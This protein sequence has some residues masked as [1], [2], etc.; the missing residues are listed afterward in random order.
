MG[1]KG[2]EG[3]LERAVEGTFSRLFRSGLSPVEFGRKLVRE[4]DAHRT[5]G[6]DGRTIVP[7]AF[8]VSI[9]AADAE[10]LADLL[11]TLRRELA[12][13]A[14]EH[15]RDEGYGFV[16]PVEVSIEVDEAMRPGVLG[17]HSR[18]AEGEGG[19][20]P[21]SLV[22]PTGDIVPLGEFV[23]SVGRQNDCTIVLADPNVSRRHAEFRPSGDG[24]AVVDLGSTNG[25]KVN[26][27][28]VAEQRLVDGDQVRFGNTV[29]RFQA[30]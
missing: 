20:Q 16:G 15:A 28:R 19:M 17:V 24:F 12:D 23:V 14:R 5:V 26:E 3:R 7:N 21:G 27:A 11:G 25:T 2:F 30:S 22:L 18:F 10:Q 6:V 1:I 13:A 4:M 9:S 8:D 29:M